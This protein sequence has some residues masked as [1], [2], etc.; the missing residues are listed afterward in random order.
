VTDD[1]KRA[2]TRGL[3]RRSGH[4]SEGSGQ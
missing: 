3:G 2:T 1:G 4:W